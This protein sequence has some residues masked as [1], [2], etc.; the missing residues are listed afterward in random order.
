MLKKTTF[1]KKFG[2]V[3]SDMAPAINATM[4]LAEKNQMT[5]DAYIPEIAGIPIT[6]L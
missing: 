6:I 2:N 3:R 5:L 4:D 1:Y